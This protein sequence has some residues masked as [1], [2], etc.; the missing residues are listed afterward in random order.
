MPRPEIKVP[1]LGSHRK[2]VQFI[3]NHIIKNPHMLK[4][5]SI[6]QIIRNLDL[7]YQQEG[8]RVSPFSF[9]QAMKI[10]E[11]NMNTRTLWESVRVGETPIPETLKYII[12]YS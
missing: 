1:Q 5:A 10:L 11:D 4:T 2:T 6:Q 8:Q 3:I 12:D 7:G 9:Q